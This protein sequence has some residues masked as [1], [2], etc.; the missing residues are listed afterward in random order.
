MVLFSRVMHNILC[1]DARSS[2]PLGQYGNAGKQT[3]RG[4]LPPQA[5]FP[6]PACPF[7]IG[8]VLLERWSSGLRHR[9]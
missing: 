2:L 9:T 5:A 7:T 3:A 8:G 6:G 4:R 1:L